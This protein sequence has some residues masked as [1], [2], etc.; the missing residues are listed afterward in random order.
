MLLTVSF[1]FLLTTFPMNTTL[2]ATSCWTASLP[3]GLVTDLALAAKLI[4]VRTVCELL[5]YVNHSINFFLYCATGQKFRRQLCA[6]WRRSPQRMHVTR[7]D[8]RAVNRSTTRKHWCGPCSR[9]MNPWTTARENGC[10]PC[11]RPVNQSTA[12]EQGGCHFGHPYFT[13]REPAAVHCVVES[14]TG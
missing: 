1:A 12:R 10:P 14:S 13:A 8:T 7:F 5:M 6:L 3:D 2:I 11:L 9:S 4:L